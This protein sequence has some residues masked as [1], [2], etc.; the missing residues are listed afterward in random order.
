MSGLLN[1]VTGQP[2]LAGDARNVC[3]AIQVVA[4]DR[5]AVVLSKL[6]ASMVRADLASHGCA[7]R[8]EVIHV[9]GGIRD[10]NVLVA[11]RKAVATNPSSKLRA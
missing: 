7:G 10:L 6:P 11:L 5:P 9:P 3:T 1:F 2:Q 4:R 8:A